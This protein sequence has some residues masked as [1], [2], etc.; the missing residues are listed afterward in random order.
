MNMKVCL[1][2]VLFIAGI[3]AGC[4]TENKEVLY[5]AGVSEELATLRKE[6][7]KDLKY[8][9]FFHIPEEKTETVEGEVKVSFRL[10]KAREIVLDFRNGKDKL[11]AISVNGEQSVYD[12]RNEHIVLPAGKLKKGE[13]EVEIRFTAGN[14]SLNRNDD[15]L[16]TLLVPDRARTV[17]PCFEQ[18][19][20]KAEFTLSLEIPATWQAV[21]N[22]YCVSDTVASAGHRIVRFAP[23]EPLSTYL[24]SFVAGKLEHRE[25]T[26]EGRTVAA[27]YR[28]TD[29]KKVAQLDIIFRQILAALRWQE[30]FTGVPYPFAKYDIVILPGFQYGGMEH[31]GA[32]LYNDTQLFLSENAT[33]DEELRRAQLIAHETAHM[34]FGDYVTMAWFDDVW[35]KE[36]FANYFAASICE[37]VFPDINHS[38]N[39]L[40]TYTTA[41]LSEDRTPGTTS[42]KQPLS[43]LNDAGLIYGQIIY[44]KAPVMMKK[45]VDLM[46]ND[47][48]RRGI[49]EYVRTF[50][51]G[52]ATWED[53]IRI[54][55]KYS[56][57]D[58][59]AFS[60]VWVHEKGMPHISFVCKG[61]QLEIRQNDSY[62]RNLVWPQRFNVRLCGVQDTTLEVCIT[63]PVTL[64]DLPFE[65]EHLIPNADG[66]GYGLLMPDAGTLTWL[67]LNWQTFSDET[68]RQAT[69]MLLYENYLA[70]RISDSDWFNSLLEGIAVEKNPL[71]AAT[72]VSYCAYPLQAYTGMERAVAEQ[73]LY[74]MALSHPLISCRTQLL[75][76]LIANYESKDLDR[77]FYSLWKNQDNTQLNENDYTT[78]AYE[79]SIRHPEGSADILAG[80]RGRIVDPDRLR[81]FDFISRA[82]VADTLQLD[83]LFHS[84]LDAENRRIEPWTAAALRYLNHPLRDE[85]AVK[86]IPPGLSAMR[87]VQRTGDIFFPANWAKALLLQ[88]RSEAAYR[89]VKAFLEAHPDYPPL[90]RNKILQAAYPLY[91]LYDK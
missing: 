74:G 6:L 62:G 90:L 23:T 45:M 38:L 53:L 68:E 29:P 78:L 79:L 10:D 2:G 91:R 5:D 1:W 37:P 47:N 58:L 84:F 55:G 19:D 46:G 71:I 61:K 18:P 64:V 20:L 7:V 39:W 42:I 51:Y 72:L 35:T 63:T 81:Q 54:M 67:L 66:R 13:N 48:F 65:P 70:K 40:R 88:H 49:Q 11:H 9:L 41:S 69:L 17:F 32:T 21:S 73:K 56:E 14:Q 60:R 3:L 52:N 89:E 8:S 12:F 59:E 34:W 27:Y 33:P 43:N 31:T 75:R 36:V 57:V 83:S 24:F 44:N 28:E 77:H 82:V 80:Q 86:Y 76:V 50:A 87:E 16:Y 4:K 22:T 30:E 85:Y 25:Y 26:E 15:F